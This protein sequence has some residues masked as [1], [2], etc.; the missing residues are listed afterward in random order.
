MATKKEMTREERTKKEIARLTKVFG[1]LDGN[2]KITVDSL[3]RRAAFMTITIEDLEREINDR[4]EVFDTY[5]HGENQ[6]GKKQST[7]VQTHI[8]MTKN[9]ST[10]IRQLT[11]LVPAEKKTKSKLAMLRDE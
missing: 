2:K 7:E 6:S 8:A 1:D 5:Q 9:L 11:E 10:V 3:I 4:G